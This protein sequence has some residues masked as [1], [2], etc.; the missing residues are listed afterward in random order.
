VTKVFELFVRHAAI[1]SEAAGALRVMLDG[2]EAV[3]RNCNIVM[4]RERDPDARDY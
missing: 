1:I 4:E 3:A 2:D